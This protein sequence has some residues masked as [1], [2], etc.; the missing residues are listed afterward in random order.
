MEFRE[1]LAP[2]LFAR[3]I[4]QC[5]RM[6]LGAP[7]ASGR[8][9]PVAIPGAFVDLQAD[10]VIAAVGERVDPEPLMRNGIALDARGR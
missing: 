3:G 9:S 1:L 6:E 7:D 5:Q 4:L 10:S 2:V 8:K